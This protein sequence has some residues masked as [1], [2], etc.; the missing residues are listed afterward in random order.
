MLG[1]SHKGHS[2]LCKPL[3]IK[4]KVMSKADF[5]ISIHE[6]IKVILI[7]DENKGAMSVTNDIEDVIEE[8]QKTLKNGCN[9]S[10]YKVV[11]LNSYGL[12]DR[13]LIKDN[14]FLDFG[15]EIDQASWQDCLN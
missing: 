5:T 6:A 8:V 15:E 13:I 7:T 4:E 3:L 9:I 10:D 12:Y 1:L 11:S 14:E 2:V